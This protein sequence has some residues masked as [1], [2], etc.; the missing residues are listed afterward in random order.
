MIN[1]GEAVLNHGTIDEVWGYCENVSVKDASD[2]TQLKNGQGDTKG[3]IYTDVRKEVSWEFT[4]LAGASD[5]VTKADIIGSRLTVKT[6]G[7]AEIEV[8]VDSAEAKYKK[9]DVETWGGT[10][11]YYPELATDPA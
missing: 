11:V 7:V 5:P 9:G 10:G 2:K 1:K 8:L 6:E 3:V 4:P